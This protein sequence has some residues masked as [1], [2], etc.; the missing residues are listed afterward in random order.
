[1]WHGLEGMGWGWIGLALLHLA[2]LLVLCVAVLIALF[3][4][5]PESGA[6]ALEILKL[7]YAKGE[8]TREQFEALKRDLVDGMSAHAGT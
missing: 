7:R 6:A 2:L 8:I 5:R 1:M 4:R 3:R